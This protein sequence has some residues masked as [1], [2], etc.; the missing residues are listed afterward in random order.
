MPWQKVTVMSEKIRFIEL[1]SQPCNFSKLCKEFG[2][3]RETGYKWLKRHANEGVSG[4]NERSKRPHSSAKQTSQAIVEAILFVRASYPRWGGDKIRTYLLEEM[5]YQ[6]MVSEK[7]IDRILKKNGCINPEESAKHQAFIRFEHENPNDLWQMDFKG[8]FATSIERCHPLTLLDDHSRFSLLIKACANERGETVKAALIQVFREYGLPLSM[9]MDNGTPWG[10]SGDQ[11]HTAFSVWLIHL[12]IWV[13]HSRPLHP[14]TQ[15]KLERFHRTLKEELLSLY[16]FDNLSHAQQGFDWWR[17]IYNEKRPHGAI[18]LQVPVKRYKRS[19]REYPEVLS[20]IEYPSDMQVR[21]VQHGG[22]ISYEG[23][24]YRV[25]QA[26]HG[27]PVGLKEN[28]V[29]GLLDVYFCHQK[30]LKI[31]VHKL[32]K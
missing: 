25:G 13:S 9:T 18:D 7:T 22:E 23:K 1:G 4:L 26:F 31:D 11:R 3:S 5:G 14:Q 20:T 2:I 17:K 6:A 29:D 16:S 21:K 30:V 32:G 8:H 28:T 12:G 24:L 15:G 27:Y 19:E 10:Y